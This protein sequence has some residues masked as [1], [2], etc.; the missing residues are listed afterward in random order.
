MLQRKNILSTDIELD[1]GIFSIDNFW[2]NSLLSMNHAMKIP[3][4]R[5]FIRY[6]QCL[7]I[8]TFPETKL[9]KKFLSVAIEICPD[10]VNKIYFLLSLLGM[11]LLPGR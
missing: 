9:K 7:A 2:L 8:D 10:L 3:K 6:I 4:S 11:Y 1:N 5:E